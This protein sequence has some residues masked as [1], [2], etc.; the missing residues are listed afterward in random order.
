MTIFSAI[1]WP[2]VKQAQVTPWTALALEEAC[3]SKVLAYCSRRLPTRTDAEDAT[4]ETFLAASGRL[5]A[6]PE[7][8][9]EATAW[10]LGIARR[11]AT[12]IL[13]REQ[14]RRRDVPL[15][16]AQTLLYATAT[17]QSVLQE[18]ARQSVRAL[19]ATLRPE[20]REV[21]LLKYAEELSLRQI[22]QVL[23]KSEGAVS[24]LLQRAR[25]AAFA[26]GSAYFH[27]G[28]NS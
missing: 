6:C 22:A 18:E 14:K 24:S 23:G 13:R 27:E 12:D 9:D 19:L 7:P 10:L 11:K 5:S 3:L 21:L 16:Q 26:Q 25:A 4:V 8:R 28:K 1:R 15:E 2:R 17:E 20:Y